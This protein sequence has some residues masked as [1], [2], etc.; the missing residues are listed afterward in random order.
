MRSLQAPHTAFKACKFQIKNGFLRPESDASVCEKL[1]V[2]TEF[3]VCTNGRFQAWED[4]TTSPQN[5][6]YPH[7]LRA[8][9]KIQNGIVNFFSVVNASGD[10]FFH[11]LTECD[12]TLWRRRGTSRLW[13]LQTWL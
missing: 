9:P 5:K 1:R 2:S 7:V 13:A 10:P 6:V 3:C 11:T 4:G 12:W 8:R